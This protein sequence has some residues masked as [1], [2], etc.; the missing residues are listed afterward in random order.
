MSNE[1]VDRETKRKFKFTDVIILI[2][3]MALVAG[4][5]L[6]VF[7]YGYSN[8]IDYYKDAIGQMTSEKL[9]GTVYLK[10]VPIYLEGNTGFTQY[11][12]DKWTE[13][14]PD[15]LL[16]NCTG[17]YICQKGTN[18]TCDRIYATRDWSDA[19][20]QNPDGFVISGD[21]NVYLYVNRKSALIHELM[22]LYNRAYGL[23][24]SQQVIDLYTKCSAYL[25]SN[26]KFNAS[27]FLSES[28]TLYFINPKN[29]QTSNLQ[30]IYDYFQSLFHYYA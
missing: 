18:S 25:N 20:S 11:D 1:Y 12:L 16:Q 3:F 19:N 8:P 26:A 9:S 30:P 7:G 28:A 24:T 4:I 6:P 21:N 5:I 29:L 27:E 14:V 17:I 23:D 13:E 22:H 15:V 10:N 2:I